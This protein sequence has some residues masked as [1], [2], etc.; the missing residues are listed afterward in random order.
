M[1]K[2]LKKEVST[3]QDGK[4]PTQLV[5]CMIQI[6]LRDLLKYYNPTASEVLKHKVAGVGKTLFIKSCKELKEEDFVLIIKTISCLT[7]TLELA[8]FSESKC[9]SDATNYEVDQLRSLYSS[10]CEDSGRL[11][12]NRFQFVR[13]E[14]DTVHKRRAKADQTC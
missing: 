5:S 11:F 10:L 6:C 8:K 2:I 4:N 14:L 1:N 13:I 9:L 3:N 12:R 7:D